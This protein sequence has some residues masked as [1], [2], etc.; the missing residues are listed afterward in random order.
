MDIS[1]TLG[2]LAGA[3]VL[4]SLILLGGDLRMFVD[5]HA[6]IA[7]FGGAFAATLMTIDRVY[8]EVF[9]CDAAREKVD[10]HQ[11]RGYILSGG[12]N[13]IYEDGAPQMPD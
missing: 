12:P 2:L 11:P 3:A 4:A 5:F 13:S 8:A 9:P 6:F 1:T 10:V 7:I